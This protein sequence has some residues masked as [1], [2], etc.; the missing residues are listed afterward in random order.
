M[1]GGRRENLRL[2]DG[3]RREIALELR[4]LPDELRGVVG[5]IDAGQW[6]GRSGGKP[7]RW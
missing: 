4:D 2:G 7:V 6:H 5:G 3:E 1:L